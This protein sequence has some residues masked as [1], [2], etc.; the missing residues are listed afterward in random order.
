M[1]SEYRLFFGFWFGALC[2]L[3]Y[4]GFVG[5]CLVL[6]K[7]RRSESMNTFGPQSFILFLMAHSDSPCSCCK[8]VA[9]PGNTLRKLLFL[10]FLAAWVSECWSLETIREHELSL[11]TFCAW[12]LVKIQ[13]FAKLAG[14]QRGAC[15]GQYSWEGGD[16]SWGE[17]ARLGDLNLQWKNIACWPKYI[18]LIHFFNVVGRLS[19]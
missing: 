9:D 19:L 2:F 5:P 4:V 17:E 13:L 1:V 18:F 7:E 14:R 6:G 8:K 10:W 15:V 16:A 12:N 3:F 11:G